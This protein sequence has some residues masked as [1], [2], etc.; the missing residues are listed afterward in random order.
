MLHLAKDEYTIDGEAVW[1]MIRG[2]QN[3]E[4]EYEEGKTGVFKLSEIHSVNPICTFGKY[5]VSLHTEEG[6]FDII[7]D[8]VPAPCALEGHILMLSDPVHSDCYDIYEATGDRIKAAFYRT[9]N[10]GQIMDV[11]YYEDG[12]PVGREFVRVPEEGAKMRLLDDVVYLIFICNGKATFA[13][14]K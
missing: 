10:R 6:F 7:E 12:E 11:E 3:I 1:D 13:V 2:G 4:V 8:T 9:W 14:K 5:E